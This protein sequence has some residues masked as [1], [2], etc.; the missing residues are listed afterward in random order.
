MADE[1]SEQTAETPVRSPWFDTIRAWVAAFDEIAPG[2]IEGLYVVGSIALRDWQPGSSDIDIIAI[3]AEPADDEMAGT[4][5]TARAVFSDRHPFPT[6]DG[7][8]L[9]WGDLIVPPQSV[10]RPWTLNGRFRHDAECFEINP[11]TWYT[12]A[13]YGVQVRGPALSDIPI[14]RDPEGLVRF[15]EDNARDYWV[16][17]LR[18]L[19]GSIGELQP[20]DTLPSSVPVWCLLGACR[21]LYTAATG[22]VCSKTSA[23]HWAAEILGE[24]HRATCHEVVRLR[25]APEQEIGLPL[26]RATASA[27][28]EAL[29][30]ITPAR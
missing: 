11:A 5:R 6:V 15:V 20:T 12:L 29:R 9:A 24:Q 26:L 3:T 19:R 4:L 16:R 2:A 14:P 10:T 13:T 27:M 30:L 17:V 7:P 8:F 18:E 25:A 23:G 21:M 28:A 1:M 22:D